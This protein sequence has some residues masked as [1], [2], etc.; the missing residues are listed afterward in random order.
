MW[1]EL[2]QCQWR[3]RRKGGIEYHVRLAVKIRLRAY[4]VVFPG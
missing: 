2:N 3:E 4:Q 1:V